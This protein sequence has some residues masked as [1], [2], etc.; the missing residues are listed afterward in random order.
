MD[1]FKAD[2]AATGRVINNGFEEAFGF[3]EAETEKMLEDYGIADRIPE[4]KEWYD[5]YLFGETE[6][7]NPWSITKYVSEMVMKKM[8]FPEPYWANTSSNRIIQDMILYADGKMKKELDILIGGGTIEKRVHEDITYGDIHESE[9][10]LWNFLFFTG[11][12]KKVSERKE[13]EDIYLTMKI[14]NLEIRSIYR[15]QIRSW[16]EEIVKKTDRS[17]LY[18]AVLD[19]DTDGM[20]DYVSDLLRKSISVFDSEE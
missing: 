6:I 20:A 9:D 3:T 19:G 7:Y 10:N 5:G 4:A 13:R 14:P 15:N 12:M 1:F 16:F 17:V 11:Y 18:K 8:K 2:S